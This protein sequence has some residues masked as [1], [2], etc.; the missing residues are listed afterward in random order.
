[1]EQA[2]ALASAEAVA[3]CVKEIHIFLRRIRRA[4]AQQ[5]IAR[6]EKLIQAVLSA[7]IRDD[8]SY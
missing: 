4:I 6:A 1:M 7:G 3:D 8:R 5:S 2:L